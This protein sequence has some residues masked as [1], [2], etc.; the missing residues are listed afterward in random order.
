MPTPTEILSPDTFSAQ[1]DATG[2]PALGALKRAGWERFR[3]LP[4]PQRTT[5][6]WRFANLNHIKLDGFSLPSVPSAEV[7]AD[8][9]A[10]SNLVK[11]HAATLVFADGYGVGG[12]RLD[13]ALAARGVVFE[14]LDVAAKEHPALLEKYLLKSGTE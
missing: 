14:P 2:S 6:Q 4:L 1:L 9:L 12:A 3:E 11:D 7:R 13:P 5:E 8:A 10:R